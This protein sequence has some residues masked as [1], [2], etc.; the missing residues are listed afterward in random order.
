M[1][2]RRLPWKRLIDSSGLLV[3]AI[4]RDLGSLETDLPAVLSEA[5]AFKTQRIV[6]SGMYRFD[7]SG[8]GGGDPTANPTLDDMIR[9]AKKASVPN[10][11]IERARKRGSGEEASGADWQT[12]STSHLACFNAR[13]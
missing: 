6:I 7:Y 12:I 10:D 9:K 13:R 11:N 1:G 3:T 4:H 5:R 8:A 2:G